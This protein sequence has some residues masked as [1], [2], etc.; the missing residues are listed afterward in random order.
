MSSR[1]LELVQT[2]S[3]LLTR[4]ATV[5]LHATKERFAYSAQPL[6]G[7]YFTVILSSYQEVKNPYPGYDKNLETVKRNVARCTIPKGIWTVALPSAISCRS[8][9]IRDLS[10]GAQDLTTELNIAG[11]ERKT[12][13]PEL[14]MSAPEPK[15]LAQ[16]K[17]KK[18]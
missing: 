7:A 14:K 18:R 6:K 8:I 3:T 9:R 11:A 13:A 4:C 10:I 16:K 5:L 1:Q 15:I 12:A 17:K 2:P